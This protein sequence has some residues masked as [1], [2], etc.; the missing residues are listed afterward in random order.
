M[1]FQFLCNIGCCRLFSVKT[2]STYRFE[3]IHITRILHNI[4]K[5]IGETIINDRTHIFTDGFGRLN[6]WTPLEVF[7]RLLHVLLQFPLTTDSRFDSDNKTNT[8]ERAQMID[9]RKIVNRVRAVQ[10]HRPTR[11]SD[12]VLFTFF[13]LGRIDESLIFR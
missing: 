11:S 9:R 10:N 7:I 2:F 6:V 12:N 4:T 3:L 1:L 13:T 8:N 5:N